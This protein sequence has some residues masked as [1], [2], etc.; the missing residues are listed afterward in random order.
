MCKARRVTERM[1]KGARPMSQQVRIGSSSD[2]VVF[3]KAQHEQ[4]KE[5]FEKVFAADG[6][7]RA[8]PFLALRQ[9][10]AVH[11]TAEEEIVHPVALR[12]LP[13]GEAIVTARL[14]EEK[15]AKATRAELEG[16]AVASREFE[17]ELLRLQAAVL[18]HAEREER[19]EF[20]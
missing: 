7:Q 8:E 4:I 1:S 2:L 20:D 13:S 14:K 17:T 12:E 16:L 11:E 3:L 19:E 5:L 15:A 10:I 18:A 9:F 6:S